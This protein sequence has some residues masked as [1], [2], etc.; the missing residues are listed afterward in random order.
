MKGILI[1]PLYRRLEPGPGKDP[2]GFLDKGTVLEITRL[3]PGD[4]MEGINLWFQA[5]DGFFYW[6]GGINMLVDNDTVAWQTLDEKTKM[7]VLS[8]IVNDEANQLMRKAIGLLG[9]GMGYKNDNEIAGLALTVFVDNKTPSENLEKEISYK[10]VHGIPVDIKPVTKIEHQQYIPG[11]I[12]QLRPDDSVPMQMGG[13]VSVADS[14]DYGSR[15][16][17]LV[18][19]QDKRY[20]LTCFHVLLNDFKSKKTFPFPESRPIM[21]T[22]PGATNTTTNDR[23]TQPV[24]SGIYSPKY[25]F[26]LVSLTDNGDFLNAFDNRRFRGIHTSDTIPS[27]LGKQ[28]SMAGASSSLQQGKVLDTKVTIFVGPTQA[29]FDN[30]IAVEKISIAGDSGAPV[31]DQDNKVVGIIIAGDPDGRSYVLPVFRIIFQ[32]GYNLLK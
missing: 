15:G 7:A 6:S 13:S 31:I 2:E 19:K 4:E 8:S 27:L 28:V 14:Q 24:V 16:L 23:K 11:G 17:V 3:I 22:Y 5:D 1:Y 26:A 25:D 29:Q 18:D 12:R 20:L 32:Q 30:V 21:A 10:G 9:Y